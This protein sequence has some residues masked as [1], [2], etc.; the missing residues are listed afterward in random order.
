MLDQAQALQEALRGWRRHLHQHPELGFQEYQTAR[1]ISDRL[2]DMEIEAQTGVGKTG[3]VAE[4][5]GDGPIVAIRADIDA[6]PILEQTGADYCS[7]APGTMHACGH[8]AHTA[9]ALGAAKLLSRMPLP[10]RVRFLFQPCEETVDADGKGGADRMVEDG[11][12]EGVQAVIG[13][14][15]DPTLPAGTIAVA[16]GTV[17]A[18][19]DSFTAVISGRG[20]HAAYPHTGIDPIWL[21]SQVLNAIYGLRGRLIDPFAPSVITVGTIH[22]GTADN[23]IPPDVTITGTIR[24][25]D[26]TT[27]ERLHAGLESACGIARSYGGDYELRISRG[28]PPVVN[29]ESVAAAVRA[30]ALAM[31]G[32]DR[33][34]RQQPQCGADDFSVFASIAPGCYFLL[35]VKRDGEEVYECHH[36]RFDIDETALPVGSALLASAALRLLRER[37]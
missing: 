31:L 33:V 19:P 36:P 26:N 8:D 22:G 35:G 6:L 13:L 1:F 12:M 23:I 11:A 9:V 3:V 28:C 24:T 20:T 2:R 16:P 14:H 7:L 21:A 17:A 27:R 25:F 29:D 5:G 34:A 30:E 10:G 32:D 37:Q 4:I 15:V 18:A